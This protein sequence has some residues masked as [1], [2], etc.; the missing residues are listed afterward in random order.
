MAILPRSLLLRVVVN[1]ELVVDHTA[2][3]GP[4]KTSR[5]ITSQV[6]SAEGSASSSSCM[7]SSPNTGY[8]QT[9]ADD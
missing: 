1:Q 5:T 3:C 8:S 2:V 7:L 6:E 9:T 4:S